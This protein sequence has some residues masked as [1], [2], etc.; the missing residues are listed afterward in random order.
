MISKILKKDSKEFREMKLRGR[1][2]I[3]GSNFAAAVGI[4]TLAG[5]WIDKKTGHEVLFKVA[6]AVLGIVW[7]MY[8]LLKLAVFLGKGDGPGEDK[9]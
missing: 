2:I 7:G 9:K 5:H 8:E 4:L 6:G 1:L 3:V